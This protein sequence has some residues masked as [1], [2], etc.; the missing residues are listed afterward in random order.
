MSS[1]ERSNDVTALS[2]SLQPC[3]PSET[4]TLANVK[5]PRNMRIKVPA[6]AEIKEFTSG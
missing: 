5:P 6:V 3:P 1:D 4:V 2:R